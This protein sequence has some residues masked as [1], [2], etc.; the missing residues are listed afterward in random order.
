MK[1][2]LL[3]TGAS[4]RGWS[5]Y[6]SFL[7]C[8][9]LGAWKYL[10]N[11]GVAR[12]EVPNS[13]P[14]QRGSLLHLMLAHHYA[15]EIATAKGQDP[16]LYWTP[17][18]AIEVL[19]DRGFD[20]SY[21]HDC[22][23]IF[24][25]YLKHWVDDRWEPLYVEREIKLRFGASLYTMRL[26]FVVRDRYTKKIH[27]VDHKSSS[28]VDPSNITRYGLSGQFLG[29]T[30]AG[31]KLYGDDF[32][33]VIINMLPSRS[34]GKLKFLR[35][36]LPAAP[37]ALQAFPKSIEHVDRIL[38]R[39]ESTPHDAWPRVFSEHTCVTSYGVCDFYAQCQWTQPTEEAT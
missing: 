6:E 3:D 25:A 39:Y 33:G 16:D 29:A 27:F 7:R 32:G 14:L 37:A 31:M 26:D 38:K 20:E 13:E 1:K 23:T 22:S 4:Q 5:F 28:K 11:G 15:R 19:F 24:D 21:R 10:H 2:I 30:W 35:L 18:A 8:P 36:A 17:H 12:S 34:Y 9:Q